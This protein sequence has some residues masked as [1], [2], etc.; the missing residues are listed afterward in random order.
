MTVT[1]TQ[2]LAS[3]RDLRYL[4]DNSPLTR[5]CIEFRK[6]EFR[7]RDWD[8][9]ADPDAGPIDPFELG[10]RRANAY[11]FLRRPDPDYRSFSSW[12]DAAVHE[13]LTID[14]LAILMRTGRAT[15]MD[16]ACLEPVV[17]P[18]G[19][20]R[21]YRHH[22]CPVPRR[23]L[24]ELILDGPTP[25]H[26]AEYGPAEI[27]ICRRFA[28]RPWTPFGFSPVEEAITYRNDGTV[29]VEASE[30]GM[31][32]SF[33]LSAK[34]FGMQPPDDYEDP[35]VDTDGWLHQRLTWFAS[36]MDKV[37]GN[38]GLRWKWLPADASQ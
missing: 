20:I 7:A 15:I 5:A 28:A 13:A 3:F 21:S 22:I 10:E 25:G 38:S 17:G 1:D 37:L 11:G 2:P 27:L 16:G 30:A 4:A 24:Q 12:L 35:E 18:K 14:T 32:G 9:V 33:A 6:S 29:D 19:W 31:F 23:T 26:F 36:V 8:L 34:A